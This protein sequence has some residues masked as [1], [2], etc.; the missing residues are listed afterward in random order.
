M[1]LIGYIIVAKYFSENA[2]KK[3]VQTALIAIAFI[4][5]VC[6]FVISALVAPAI[7]NGIEVKKITIETQ[8]EVIKIEKSGENYKVEIQFADRD[9]NVIQV[10]FTQI[11][12]PK[13]N[14]SV[15]Y[16][17]SDPYKFVTGLEN[18]YIDFL[19]LVIFPVVVGVVMLV[20][21][22]CAIKKVGVYRKYREG[23][24]E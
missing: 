6:C 21:G 17:P 1:N 15:W 13:E 2:H 3:Q 8:A 7:L 19:K 23:I 11:S 16:L 12:E 5:A 18:P 9:G 14:I 4:G 20:D 10:V 22:V 24:Y